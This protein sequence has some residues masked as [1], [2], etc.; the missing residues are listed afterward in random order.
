MV[1]ARAGIALGAAVLLVAALSGGSRDDPRTPA[2]LPGL[3]P[4]F[5]GVA[6]VGS[7]GR[8]AAVDAYGDLVDLREPGPAGRA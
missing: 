8:T 3:P 2:G 5:L 1:W 4:P 7:G 6:V